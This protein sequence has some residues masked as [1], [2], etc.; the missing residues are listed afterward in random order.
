MKDDCFAVKTT[1]VK[2]M[3]CLE[4]K[5]SCT[6]L[7]EALCEKTHEKEKCPF[8]K[9]RKQWEQEMLR[10]HGTTNMDAV[11]KSYESS[12]GGLL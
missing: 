7:K 10:I 6:A 9:S 1:E 2:I 5:R 8:Y 4:K 11:L 3:G 12:H